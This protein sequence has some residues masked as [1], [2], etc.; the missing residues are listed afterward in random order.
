MKRKQSKKKMSNTLFYLLSFFFAES[1]LISCV[2]IL[3][4]KLISSEKKMCWKSCTL[5]G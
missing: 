5:F 3:I 2:A 4:G 1:N